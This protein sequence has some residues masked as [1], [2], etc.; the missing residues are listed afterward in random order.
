[1][2]QL[3][4]TPRRL[5]TELPVWLPEEVELAKWVAEPRFVDWP[6]ALRTHRTP[7]SI[8]FQR[9]PHPGCRLTTQTAGW[10]K[11]QPA[12][13]QMDGARCGLDSL[14]QLRGRDCTKQMDGRV[15]FII[16]PGGLHAATLSAYRPL[17]R[18]FSL[19]LRGG[20]FFILD[21]SVPRSVS[22]PTLRLG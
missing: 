1:M 11:C 7:I 22:A 13:K 10:R 4:I 14:T 19:L 8:R 16:W 2:T 6:H 20:H 9:T 21:S 5:P 17:A 15:G 18:N 3:A 12:S